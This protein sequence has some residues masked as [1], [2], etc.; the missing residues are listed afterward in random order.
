MLKLAGVAFM[1]VATQTGQT[2]WL[3]DRTRL[4]YA[5]RWIRRWSMINI[6]ME[7]LLGALVRFGQRDHHRTWCRCARLM[8]RGPADD[9]CSRKFRPEA[10]CGMPQRGF[11]ARQSAWWLDDGGDRD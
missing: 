1:P 7:S 3:R 10:D 8:R 4:Y 5:V 11:G 6:F 9:V 2:A